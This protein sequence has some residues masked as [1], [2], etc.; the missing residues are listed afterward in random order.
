MERWNERLGKLTTTLE[1]LSGEDLTR[2]VQDRWKK[3]SALEGIHQQV[4]HAAQHSRQIIYLAKM[5]R[6][7]MELSDDLEG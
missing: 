5:R 4:V 2:D 1:D 3:Y 6:G 7:K